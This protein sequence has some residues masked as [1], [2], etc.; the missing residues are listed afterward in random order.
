MTSMQ[1]ER[2]IVYLKRIAIATEELSKALKKNNAP[3]HELDE[4]INHVGYTSEQCGYDK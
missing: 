4:D 2:L 1:E 3:S